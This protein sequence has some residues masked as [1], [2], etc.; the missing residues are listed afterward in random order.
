MRIVEN[1]SLV[2]LPQGSQSLTVLMLSGLHLRSVHTQYHNRV[3][4]MHRD[5]EL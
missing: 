5:T 2:E 4:Q 3:S 1:L